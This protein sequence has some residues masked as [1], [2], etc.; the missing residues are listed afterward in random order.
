MTQKHHAILVM[1]TRRGRSKT[2]VTL[3]S[4]ALQSLVDSGFLSVQD[5]GLIAQTCKELN[6]ASIQESIWASFCQREY[7]MTAKLPQTIKRDQ[8]FRLLYKSWSAP[9]VKRRPP[10]TTLGPPSCRL[11][12]IDLVIHI[13]YE[14]RPIFNTALNG[15]KKLKTL[16]GVNGGVRV[17][18]RNPIAIGNAVWDFTEAERLVYQYGLLQER[19]LPVRCENFDPSKLSV[20]IHLYRSLDRGMCCLFSSK[21]MTRAGPSR[22]FVHPK[23]DDSTVPITQESKFDLDKGHPHSTISYRRPLP[24]EDM[25]WPLQHTPQ[26]NVILETFPDALLFETILEV[27]IDGNG[28]ACI[29]K[30]SLLATAKDAKNGVYRR[31]RNNESHGVTLLHVLSE[32]QAT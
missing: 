18:L 11:G 17:N 20:Q 29:T 7:P 31:F 19:G 13:K 30:I 27:G 28:A 26:A 10:P 24:G 22:L 32:L 4:S 5:V 14:G 6:T 1:Q 16:F 21:T 3:L 9:I 12:Q 8:G 23:N 2:A 15:E 25:A